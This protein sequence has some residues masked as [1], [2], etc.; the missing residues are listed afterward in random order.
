M[1]SAEDLLL[2]GK[3]VLEPL[4]QHYGFEFELVDAAKG[5][6][7]HFAVGRYSNG[8]RS[9][10]LHVRHALGIVEY[11]WREQSINHADYMTSLGVR[12]RA[13]YP[14]FSGDP[15][16]S[17]SHLLSDL[18]DYCGEFLSGSNLEAFAEHVAK[19]HGPGFHSRRLP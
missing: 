1:S 5:S 19:T 13:A 2:Q 6:G 14:G 7:G 16:D 10:T 4:L 17:F 15:L 18:Q 3:A 12:D 11:R 8:D 9:I